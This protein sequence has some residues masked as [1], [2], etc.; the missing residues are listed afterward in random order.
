MAYGLPVLCTHVD[1]AEENVVRNDETGYIYKKD[2]DD[3]VRYIQSKSIE[4]WIRMGRNASEL[5]FGEFSLEKECER[6]IE[7]INDICNC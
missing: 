2:V 1:G 4:D 5:M 6:F 7:R 3:V